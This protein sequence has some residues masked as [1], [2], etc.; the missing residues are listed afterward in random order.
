MAGKNFTNGSLFVD[1]R[2]HQIFPNVIVASTDGTV[3]GYYRDNLYHCA[4]HL[5]SHCSIKVNGYA[6]E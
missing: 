4:M 3:L 2:I 5:S 1:T 6:F